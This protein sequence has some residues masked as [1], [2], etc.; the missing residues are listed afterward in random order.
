ML[1]L[2]PLTLKASNPVNTDPIY[3]KIQISPGSKVAYVDPTYSFSNLIPNASFQ[4]GLWQSR[5][6]DC[7]HYDDQAI[8]GMKRVTNMPATGKYALE[9]DA[10]RHIACTGPNAIAVKEN[11]KLY[12]GFDYQSPYTTNA[13]YHIFFDDPAKTILAKELPIKDSRWHSFSTIVS[14]P[15][16]ATHLYLSVESFSTGSTYTNVATRYAD[17]Q[18]IEVP[19]ILGSYFFVSH[20]PQA[21]KKP[22]A[23]TFTIVNPTEKLVHIQGAT[24]AFYLTM[25]EAYNPNWRLAMAGTSGSWLAN[26]DHFQL[27]DFGNGWYIKVNQL[28][29]QQKSCTKNPDG[30]YN[31]DMKIEFTPQAWFSIGLLISSAAVIVCIG[32]LGVII[33]NQRHRAS[34][35]TRYE[36][37][38]QIR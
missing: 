34:R 30:T 13:A 19:D 11:T 21:N 24:T 10:A 5:T 2:I 9:L 31:L 35:G 15:D 38:K 29:Q 28:C 20:A 18:L 25:S 12:L 32:T 7:D 6:G 27:D 17:F 37:R 3:K 16:G 33:I 26:T 1:Q 36:L 14:V 22:R 23:V 8:L 4:S